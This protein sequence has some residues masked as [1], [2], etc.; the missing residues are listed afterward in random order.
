[1]VSAALLGSGV[2]VTAPLAAALLWKLFSDNAPGLL[3]TPHG[4]PHGLMLTGGSLFLA[5]LGGVLAAWLPARRGAKTKILE[6]I[7][8]E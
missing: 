5:G 7:A 2:L 8:Y 1:M 3:D 4:L 6:A